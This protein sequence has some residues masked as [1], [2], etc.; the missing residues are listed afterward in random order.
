MSPPHLLRAVR[1]P[2]QLPGRLYLHS[3]PGRYESLNAFLTESKAAGIIH[4]LCLASAEEIALKS[5]NYGRA[6]R[7]ET[8][9]FAL[10]HHPISG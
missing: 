6:I 2:R 4:V 10:Q 5:P 9:P 8:L 1:I 7:E 3:M